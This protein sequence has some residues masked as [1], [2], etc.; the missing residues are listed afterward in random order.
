MFEWLLKN[1]IGWLIDA[2][3]IGHNIENM[4]DKMSSPYPLHKFLAN[5]NALTINE[6]IKSFIGLIVNLRA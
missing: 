1:D 2:S 5:V 3:I 4:N 6:S